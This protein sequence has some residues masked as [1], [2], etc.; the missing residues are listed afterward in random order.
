MRKEIAISENY[1]QVRCCWTQ[2]QISRRE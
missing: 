2:G 1:S